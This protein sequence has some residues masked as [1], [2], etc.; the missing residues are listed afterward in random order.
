MTIVFAAVIAVTALTSGSVKREQ[1]VVYGSAA[2][3]ENVIPETALAILEQAD[4]FELL[5]LNP[6]YQQ[7][8]AEGDFHGYRV[9]GTAVINDIE[10][11]KKLVFEFKKSVAENPG[12][13]AACFNPRHGIRV[14]RKEKQVDFVICFECNQVHLFGAVQGTFLVTRSAQPL[15]DSVLHSRGVSVKSLEGLAISPGSSAPQVQSETSVPLPSEGLTPAR[16]ADGRWGYIDQK[17]AFAIKPQ[18]ES[19]KRFSEGLAP[20]ALSKKFGYIDATGRYVIQPQ[21]VF[22][23]PFSEG[24][25]LVFPDWGVNFFG[26]AE[27]YTLFV[28]AGYIDH[29][30]KM[31][32][33]ARFVENAHSFSEGLAAFQAGI[34]YTASESKWGYLDKIGNWAIQ[35]QFDIADDFSDDLAAVSIRVQQ[36]GQDRWGYID[37]TGKPVIPMQFDKA[38]PFIRGLAKVKTR[39]GWRYLD[40]Q[41]RFVGTRFLP[42]PGPIA[43]D[44]AKPV[45][46]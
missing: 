21:Y 38:L 12:I 39:D 45:P 4:H 14:T 11:R 5:S 30:G 42:S 46:H 24:L 18:F 15:F 10:T 37:K 44:G 9:L 7:I 36:G 2:D 40:K 8:P 33:N 13:V 6:D 1:L 27:G 32:I 35:P 26:H 22:A 20:A 34:N 41:G 16:S 3:V 43:I 23:E 31:I 17:K 19:A 25:A 29:T 28:R